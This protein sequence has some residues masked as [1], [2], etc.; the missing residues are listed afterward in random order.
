V[1]ALPEGEDAVLRVTRGGTPGEVRVRLGPA[2]SDEA[3]G[4][5]RLGV[6]VEPGVVVAEVRPGTPAA[7]AG[8]APGDVITAVNGEAVHDGEQLRAAVQP[9]LERAEVRLDV[10]R[11][12]EPRKV[13]ARLDDPT[14]GG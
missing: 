1:L 12:G 3:E 4:R 14:A 6:T 8:L 10:S 13:R 11:R 5:N 2:E 7:A 9:L